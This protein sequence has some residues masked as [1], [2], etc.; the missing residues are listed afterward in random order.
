MN[1]HGACNRVNQTNPSSIYC[2]VDS[3]MIGNAYYNTEGDGGKENQLSSVT[4]RIDSRPIDSSREKKFHLRL[5][6]RFPHTIGQK[7]SLL[8][9]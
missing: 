5:G 8:G 1:V 7:D 6:F 3:W 4:K 9:V 2:Q